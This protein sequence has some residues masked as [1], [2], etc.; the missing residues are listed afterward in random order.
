MSVW[1]MLWLVT[2]IMA[3]SVYGSVYTVAV[4]TACVDKWRAIVTKSDNSNVP[5]TYTV[6]I[7]WAVF[8]GIGTNKE[9]VEQR[10]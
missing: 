8:N 3:L 2:F 7:I 1:R 6:G 10:Q 9:P 4:Y 5:I